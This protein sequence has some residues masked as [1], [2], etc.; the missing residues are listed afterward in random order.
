M[1]ILDNPGLRGRA[2][3]DAVASFGDTLE[4]GLCL[5]ARGRAF[6]DILENPGLGGRA[7]VDAL[8]SLGNK[9]GDGPTRGQLGTN[10]NQHERT[11]PSW[12]Q[13]GANSDQLGLTWAT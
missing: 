4:D 10:M 6:V 1:D 8:A 2:F 13:L 9:L 12:G 5:N 7:F 3:V 11:L